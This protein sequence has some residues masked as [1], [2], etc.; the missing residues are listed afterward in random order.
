MKFKVGDKVK[1]ICDDEYA[2]IKNEEIH[3][4][5]ESNNN[6]VAL[7]GIG[8]EICMYDEKDFE[9]ATTKSVWCINTKVPHMESNFEV[10]TIGKEYQVIEQNERKYMIT[11]DKGLTMS[12]PK[13]CFSTEKPVEKICINCN[14]AEISY[15]EMPCSKCHD[16]HSFIPKQITPKTYNVVF[17]QPIN[18][19][20]TFLCEISENISINKGDNIFITDFEDKFVATTLTD[21]FNVDEKALEALKLVQKSPNKNLLRVT[22]MAIKQEEWK[23]EVFK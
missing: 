4:V 5:V 9:L 11:N 8:S 12:Y 19:T 6:K 16:H 17:A 15:L 21:S 13:S 3:E 10:I 23:E 18:S 14:H 22:G 7:K 20:I 2:Y 1:V